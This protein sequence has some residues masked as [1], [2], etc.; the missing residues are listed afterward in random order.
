M[1]LR[2]AGRTIAGT[3]LSVVPEPPRT[4]KKRTHY[5]GLNGETEITNGSGSRQ[6]VARVLLHNDYSS[7]NQLLSALRI[8]EKMVAQQRHGL[9]SQTGTIAQSF[10]HCTI[11]AV[12]RI[13]PDGSAH[14]APLL[15]VAGTLDAGWFLEV[16]LTFT[17]L[18]T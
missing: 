16:R 7:S 6:I 18:V 14:A 13:S 3:V 2:F 11:D 10:P 4:F 17:Q 12:A 15:D 5:A 1:A 9:L 8:L